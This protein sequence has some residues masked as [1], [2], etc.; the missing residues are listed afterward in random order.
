MI[1]DSYYR[2][3]KNWEG[4]P[5]TRRNVVTFANSYERLDTFIYIQNDV[6]GI[7]AKTRRKPC[8]RLSSGS[9]HLSS[10]YCEPDFPGLGYGDIKGTEDA[11]LCVLSEDLKTVELFVC[12]GKKSLVQILFGLLLDSELDSEIKALREQAKPFNPDFRRVA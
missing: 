1:L 2:F 7:N 4:K 12:K 11:I 10:I 3:E 5:F 6:S 9:S 8:Y